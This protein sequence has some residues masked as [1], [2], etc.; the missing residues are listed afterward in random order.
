MRIREEIAQKHWREAAVDELANKYA[1]QGYEVQRDAQIGPYPAD[2]LVRKGDELVVFEVKSGD[3]SKEKIKQ[4]QT[5]RNEVIHRL[6][7]RF[8]LVFASPPQE[9]SIE[10]EGIETILV[11]RLRHDPQELRELA[12]TS[13]IENVSDIVVTAVSIEKNYI[14]A[15]GLGTVS[16]TFRWRSTAEN[17]SESSVTTAESFPFEFTILLDGNLQVIEVTHLKIDVSSV[18]E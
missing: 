15:E 6:G 8:N 13:T 12:T 1:T 18:E 16:V 7:G 14:R 11:D 17:G 2:L 9:K 10:V 4:V 5:V 3:W